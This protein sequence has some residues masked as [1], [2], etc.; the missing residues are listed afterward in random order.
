MVWSGKA[1]PGGARQ[2][3][4]GTVR[5]GVAGSGGARRGVAGEAGQDLAW[6]SAARQGKGEA[7]VARRS[8]KGGK[9]NGRVA[10]ECSAV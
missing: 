5:R 9:V 2:A 7:G 6:Q 4:Q 8:S 3:W 10:R 1:R